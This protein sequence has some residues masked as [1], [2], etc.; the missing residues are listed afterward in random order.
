M[1]IDKVTTERLIED[2]LLVKCL[3]TLSIWQVGG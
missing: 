3:L 1:K 2:G